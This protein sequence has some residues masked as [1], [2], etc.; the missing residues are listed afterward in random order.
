MSGEQPIRTDFLE[1]GTLLHVL[2]DAGKGNVLDRA[3]V[4]A[5]RAALEDARRPGVLAVLFEGEGKHFSFGASVEDHL[6]AHMTGFLKGFHALFRELFALDRVLLAAVRGQCLGGGLELAAFC[7]RTFGHPS[8]CL[9]QPE[10]KLAV[11]A[12]IA[13]LVLPWRIGQPAAEELLFTGRTVNAEE[14]LASGLLDQVDEDPRQAACEWV[15]TH[16][17]SLSASSLA[18]AVRAA[19]TGVRRG[20]LRDLDEVESLYLEDLM[21]TADA[22]EGIQAFLDKRPPVYGGRDGSQE[23]V[24]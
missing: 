22:V 2:I 3:A 15:R 8:A 13:S 6:P 4:E 5:L 18:F 1:D 11:F 21:Q 9:G 10:I 17:A 19:R 20:F 12:P 16:L 7:H 14:A 24:R 23:N